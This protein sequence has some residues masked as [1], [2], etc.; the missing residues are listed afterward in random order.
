MDK[1][2]SASFY[3][4]CATVSV[5]LPI[6]LVS[7]LFDV[8]N[9]LILNILYHSCSD[10]P[11]VAA[12]HAAVDMLDSGS[13]NEQT[14][15]SLDAVIRRAYEE[16]HILPRS[17]SLVWREL[18]TDASILRSL[19]DV[20]RLGS[21]QDEALASSCVSKLDHAIVIAGAPGEGRLDIIYDAIHAVQHAMSRSEPPPDQSFFD[22]ND[23]PPVVLSR[24]LESA[25]Q[26]VPRLT[27]PPSLSLFVLQYSRQPFVIPGFIND[28]PALNEHPW[29]SFAYLRSVSG[30]GRVV[31]VEIG[32]DYRDDDWTQKMMLWD[33][34]LDALDPH[35][36]H[37]SDKRKLYL[38]QHNL[39]LQFPKLRD[40][41]LIPDYAYASLQPPKD[42][43]GYRPPA[44]EDQLVLNAWLGPPCMASPAHT[45][46]AASFILTLLLTR[47]NL[48]IHSSTSTVRPLLGSISRALT[49][50]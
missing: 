29:K 43:P 47:S 3:S 22:G 20:L 4:G 18:Y 40:D 27:S 2:L 10:C 9:P 33:D 1:V 24:S 7:V 37:T 34:L 41:I 49:V 11:E 5:F 23:T 15:A 42:F 21:T 35:K 6:M 25:H 16:M 31:P 39:F 28:W 8:F 30:P 12:I 32:D 36:P 50:P 17:N 38:A 14:S 19:G 44:N 45:V 46:S 13:W 48:R 26:P